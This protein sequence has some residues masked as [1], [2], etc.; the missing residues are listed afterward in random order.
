MHGLWLGSR[1]WSWGPGWWPFGP[2]LMLGFWVVVILL[3]AW[4]L[5]RWRS[6]QQRPQDSA[7]DILRARYAKGEITREDFE[8]IRRDLLTK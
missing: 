3:V 2:L 6:S 8:G 7:L 5:R 1:P 4:L